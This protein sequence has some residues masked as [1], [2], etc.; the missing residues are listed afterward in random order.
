MSNLNIPDWARGAV[1]TPKTPC[2][3][4]FGT[5][6]QRI[7]SAR[8]RAMNHSRET[9]APGMPY[10][11]EYPEAYYKDMA[12]PGTSPFDADLLKFLA[13]FLEAPTSASMGIN[14]LTKVV[15]DRCAELSLSKAK[16]YEWYADVREV[17]GSE[18]WRQPLENRV[19]KF[20]T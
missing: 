8:L 18:W 20:K 5:D 2:T 19:K 3:T 14:E 6:S 12:W 13:Y 10:S 17:R 11:F 1:V 4:S 15:D 7:A 9:Q 16:I